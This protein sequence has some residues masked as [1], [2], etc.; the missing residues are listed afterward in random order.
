MCSG[1]GGVLR[2]LSVFWSVLRSRRREK[3]S[4][5]EK[6]TTKWEVQEWK[7]KL[8]RMTAHEEG[9]YH[10][11]EVHKFP[12]RGLGLCVCQCPT[13][14][15]APEVTLCPDELQNGW[16]DWKPECEKVYQKR[17]TLKARWIQLAV[18]LQWHY[19]TLFDKLLFRSAGQ[20]D[21]HIK[22]CLSLCETGS[23]GGSCSRLFKKLFESESDSFSFVAV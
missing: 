22:R 21:F 19:C 16:N 8:K 5:P 23:E 12:C 14:C 9:K 11:E 3:W 1:Q 13:H 18:V 20:N 6:I 2:F 10:S 4:S 15:S 7:V 17:R